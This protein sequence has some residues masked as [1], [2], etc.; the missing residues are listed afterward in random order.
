MLARADRTE[1]VG[2]QNGAVLHFDRDIPIDL[3]GLADLGSRVI[4]LVIHGDGSMM[5]VVVS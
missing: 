4:D 3:H 2:A 5:T 1:Q